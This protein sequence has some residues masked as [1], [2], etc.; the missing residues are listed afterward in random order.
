MN[1][2]ELSPLELKNKW[3][4]ERIAFLEQE[5]AHLTGE[6]SL[7][8]GNWVAAQELASWRT[9]EVLCKQGPLTRRVAG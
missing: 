1:D 9:V 8:L 4:R 2:P 3:L 7:Y 6:A 5:N